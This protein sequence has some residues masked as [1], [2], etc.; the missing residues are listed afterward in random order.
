LPPLFLGIDL[1][2]P[3]SRNI[4]KSMSKQSGGKPPHSKTGFRKTHALEN[5]FK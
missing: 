5:Y 1:S 3:T 2:M 4:D